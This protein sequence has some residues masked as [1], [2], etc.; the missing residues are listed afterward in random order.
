MTAQNLHWKAV[1]ITVSSKIL[2]DSTNVKRCLLRAHCVRAAFIISASHYFEADIRME[3]MER[4]LMGWL[5]A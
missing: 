1:S 5:L 4:N 2:E 3:M